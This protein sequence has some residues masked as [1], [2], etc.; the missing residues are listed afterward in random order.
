MV[1]L[2]LLPVSV[3]TQGVSAL[4]SAMC[5]YLLIV[6]CTC[7]LSAMIENTW[8]WAAQKGKVYRHPINQAEYI[9]LDVDSVREKQN[10][11]ASEF[12][13]ASC[14]ATEARN[15][16]SFSGWCGTEGCLFVCPHGGRTRLAQ[17]LTL[18]RCRPLS[19]VRAAEVTLA[20]QDL[21]L[22]HLQCR[23][24]HHSVHADV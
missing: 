24:S 2:C 18:W 16:F 17:S 6:Y 20:F 23:F 11:R 15:C 9:D 4:F 10:Y 3:V 1:A 14:F 19:T 7:H 8:K 22:Q 12:E 13:T 21:F 5:R